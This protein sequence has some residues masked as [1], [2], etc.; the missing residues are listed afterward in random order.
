MR[1]K[2]KA[3]DAEKGMAVVLGE[4]PKASWV[5]DPKTGIAGRS[6]PRKA[7]VEIE[8]CGRCHSRRSVV[9]AEY[10]YGKP[11]ADTHRPAFLEAGL[12]RADGQ[13]EDEVYEYGSFLQSLMYANGVTCSDCHNP[14][15]L[16]IPVSADRVC[17]ACHAPQKFETP[18]H[19]FHKVGSKGSSCVSCHMPTRNYMVVHARHDHSFR[20]PRPDLTI[21][22]GTPNAC[23]GCH[24]NRS[25]EWA[26]EAALK[27]WGDKRR[28]QPHYGEAIAAGGEVK[29]GAGAKL[30]EL[31]GDTSRPAIVR[32][33]ALTLLGGENG[34]A[35]KE[36]LGSAVH[37]ADPYVRRGAIAAAE[38][39]EPAEKVALLASL[40]GDPIRTVRI[41]A[42]RALVSA[43]KN[44]MTS[45]DRAAFDLAL[46]EYLAT[47]QI[48]TDRAEAHVN[49]AALMVEQGNMA[50]AEA[51][52]KTAIK[53][54]PAFGGA[55]VNLADLYRL[56]ARDVEG[57]KVLRHG[58]AVS[59]A[60]AGIHH[61]LGLALVRMKRLPEALPE[62]QRA[63]ELAPREPRYAYVYGMALEASGDS[64]AAVRV[65]LAASARHPGSR[66]IL[67]ALVTVSVKSGD[68]P[69]ANASIRKLEALAPG[70][71]R[72]KALLQSLVS[73][74]KQQQ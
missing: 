68:A 2:A 22:I 51:E 52:Y 61:S 62:F 74:Q 45:S 34:S 5:F 63:A 65:L 18:L 53:L 40:L 29:S 7:H 47:Q 14:H 35:P 50:G 55:Y 27:W 57:E 10:T 41:D 26:S 60:D 36:L 20:V 32:G 37:D 6:V 31:A 1:G 13:I 30:A 4:S 17:A 42:A 71:P 19:H 16:K 38:S 28:K 3:D 48:D 23:T 9:A 24:A 66:S 59:P 70:D 12:Y 46:Q 15:D 73:Q 33:T 54:M 11:L 69:T 43:P 56:Q 8:T 72:T 25:A 39:V 49:L 58:I 21:S 67:E 44:L 64:K